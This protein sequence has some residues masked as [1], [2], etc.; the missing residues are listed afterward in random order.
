MPQRGG[1]EGGALQY[2]VRTTYL[3]QGDPV[4]EHPIFLKFL[5][6]HDK[7]LQCICTKS[8]TMTFLCWK[9]AKAKKLI[10]SVVIHNTAW[11]HEIPALYQG[12]LHTV[13]RRL[14]LK[15]F[16]I[17]TVIVVSKSFGLTSMFVHVRQLLL[18]P[19]GQRASLVP[20]LCWRVPFCYNKW[21]FI[22]YIYF[23]MFA[24]KPM[25]PLQ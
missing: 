12:R 20:K 7:V 8:D 16:F 18:F 9:G 5:I 15:T 13:K 3:C 11:T 21:L 6:H 10:F 17:S 24:Q 19:I 14:R 4:G 22:F 23:P 2:G 1:R 25:S